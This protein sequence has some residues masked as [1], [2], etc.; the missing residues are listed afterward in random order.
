MLDHYYCC[1]YMTITTT[2]AKTGLYLV[3][4][5]K[6][7]VSKTRDLSLVLDLKHKKMELY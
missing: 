7:S 1:C 3:C 2:T 6:P 4:R 5:L